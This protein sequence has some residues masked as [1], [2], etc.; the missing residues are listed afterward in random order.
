MILSYKNSVMEKDVPK[1][2]S[3]GLQIK[4]NQ[5]HAESILLETRKNFSPE[6]AM[7]DKNI[8]FTV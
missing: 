6:D 8:L 5:K 3:T 2:I 4:G 7:T 1:S